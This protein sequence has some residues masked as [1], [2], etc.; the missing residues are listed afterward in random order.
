MVAVLPITDSEESAF[1]RLSNAKSQHSRRSSIEAQLV[2]F[3]R[4]RLA[5][6]LEKFGKVGFQQLAWRLGVRAFPMQQYLLNFNG[7]PN[8]ISLL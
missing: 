5:Q 7:P 2:E 3:E 8:I 1:E 4:R 6:W